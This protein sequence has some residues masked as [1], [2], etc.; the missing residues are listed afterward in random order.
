MFVVCG[1]WFIVYCLWF[2]VWR[3]AF[4]GDWLLVIDD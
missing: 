1:L 2:G 3:L 4:G